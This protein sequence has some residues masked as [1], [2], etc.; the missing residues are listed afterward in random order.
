MADTY[1]EDVTHKTNLDGN[2]AIPVT[3][4]P[5]GTPVDRYITPD[6]LI[7]HVNTA[8]TNYKLS[9]T[10]ATND[11]TVALKTLAGT[12]PS[13]TSPIRFNINGTI[14]KVTAATSLTIV[15]GTNWMDLGGVRFGTIQQ[16]LFVKA[17]W[18]SNSSIVALSVARQPWGN[19]VS[20][21][22]STTTN[23]KH[24]YNYANFT[25]T[26]DLINIGRFACTLSLTGTGHLWT[27]PT[28]T[29]D[30]LVHAPINETRLLTYDPR[31]SGN[32]TAS[33]SLT[34]TTV[35]MNYCKYQLTGYKVKVGLKA[36]G[37]LGGSASNILYC[38]AP[39]EALSSAESP[40]VGAAFAGVACGCTITADTPDKI[41]FLKY[42]ISNFAT[43]GSLSPKCE[44]EYEAA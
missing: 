12:D 16:D 28:F 9:V 21:Y 10:V 23:E 26:D 43:S 19:L 20:D 25:S 34:F 27:V 42:D 17:V 29:S 30:T 3:S 37:T 40:V 36:T 14:R 15:D 38:M 33:G 2:E 1:F 31:T 18:D 44:G 39:W 11:L 13:T 5:S 4:D 32:W 6:D 7:N 41:S 35:T 24:L 22:S 8:G